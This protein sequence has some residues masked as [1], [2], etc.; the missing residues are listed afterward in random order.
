VAKFATSGSSFFNAFK[1]WKGEKRMQGQQIGF[2]INQGDFRMQPWLLKA[3]LSP[4]AKLTFQVMA[5]CAGGRD[6]VWPSQKFLAEGVG[7]SIRNLQRYLNELV[8]FGLIAKCREYIKGQTRNA[9]RFLCHAITGVTATVASSLAPKSEA[10]DVAVNELP[11]QPESH[12][13]LCSEQHDKMSHCSPEVLENVPTDTTNCPKQHDKMSHPLNKVLI[14][15]KLNTTPPTPQTELPVAQ[16]DPPCEVTGKGGDLFLESKEKDS[17]WIEAK[18]RLEADLGTGTF[19]AW[20]SSL[21][22]ER[23]DSEVILRAPNA[24]FSNWV[25]KHFSTQIETVLGSLGLTE[26]KLDIFTP[27]QQKHDQARKA[28]AE[29]LQKEATKAAARAAAPPDEDVDALPPEEQFERLYKAYPEYRREARKPAFEK[30]LEIFQAECHPK[31]S[32]LLNAVKRKCASESW[33]RE[34]GRYAP[35]LHRWLSERRWLD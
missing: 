7:T 5:C 21:L 28:E 25:K 1:F 29:K 32:D 15:L 27:E 14:A 17:D 31:F 19:Q 18:K 24:F 34:D 6:V 13:N 26:W 16:V 4:G 2:V 10:P 3:E 35:Q 23:N 9:Y 33:Q 12:K 20:I 22:F 30:F 8:R 11:R